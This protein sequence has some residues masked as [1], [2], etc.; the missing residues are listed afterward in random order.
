MGSESFLVP[1]GKMKMKIWLG[2]DGAIVIRSSAV[3]MDFYLGARGRTR[4]P[5]SLPLFSFL[6]TGTLICH[7]DYNTLSLCYL[8]SCY[9]IT[10]SLCFTPHSRRPSFLGPYISVLYSIGKYMEIRKL[11]NVNNCAIVPG[12]LVPR[13]NRHSPNITHRIANS[14]R[15][16]N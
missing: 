11:S 3:H 1:Q 10:S 9:R 13:G 4:S 2:V 16:L 7:R 15:N 12:D 6:F 5:Y 8:L 14:C